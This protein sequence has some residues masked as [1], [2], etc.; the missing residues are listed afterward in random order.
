M[1]FYNHE[2]RHYCG[3]D[4]HVKTMYVCMLD[5]A[6]QVLVHRNVPSTPAAFLEP[7][8]TE[9]PEIAVSAG[10]SSARNLSIISPRSG[11][12]SP[13]MRGPRALR[14][15][16]PR[17]HEALPLPRA[18][19]QRTHVGDVARHEEADTRARIEF[20]GRAG[21]A[22]AR[23]VTRSLSLHRCLDLPLLGRNASAGNEDGTERAR[24]DS[25][26]FL[27]DALLLG[28]TTGRRRTALLTRGGL[29]GVM[30]QICNPSIA[31][32]LVS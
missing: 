10:A 18:C 20:L 19:R 2:H 17:S 22:T 24:G 16:A 15:R 6:G 1:R 30:P 29:I 5:S 31:A 7:I 12:L 27:A 14:P 32:P 13:L 23:F 8:R 25:A 11:S 4:L 21:L 3:I 9:L 28:S 26:L